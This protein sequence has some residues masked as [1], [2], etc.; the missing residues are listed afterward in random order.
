MRAVREQQKRQKERYQRA[1]KK[2]RDKDEELERTRRLL[3]KMKVL[4]D[5]RQLKE[6]DEL[7]QR[8]A[9][10]EAESDEKGHRV[11][12]TR[13]QSMSGSFKLKVHPRLHIS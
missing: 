5:D 12:V 2:L 3:K 8:A 7:A 11:Q 6:R 1:V 10:Y 13:A 9:K 4:V